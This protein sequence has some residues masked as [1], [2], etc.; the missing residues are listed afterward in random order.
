MPWTTGKLLAA[1]GESSPTECITEARMAELTGLTAKQVENCCDRLRRHGFITRTGKGCHKL[2]DAGREAWQ[3]GVDLRSGPK[4][5]Q[6]SGQRRRDPGLRQRAWNALR[7]GRK[8]TIDDVVMRAAE[9]EERNAYDNVRKYVRALIRI[10]YI[11][12]MP[13]REAPLNANS[14]GCRRMLLVKD[15]GPQAPVWRASRDSVYDPNI[16][17]EVPFLEKT[18]AEQ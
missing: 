7:L 10:G 1:I 17:E 14:N 8:L 12:V 16:E 18:G 4:G 6:E 5:P 15:T 9:G 3:A 2:T 11:A 13:Q